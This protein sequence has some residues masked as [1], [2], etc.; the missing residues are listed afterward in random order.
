MT[1]LVLSEMYNA[2]AMIAPNARSKACPPQTVRAIELIARPTQAMA[3]GNHGFHYR[4]AL[5]QHLWKY[6]M[7]SKYDTCDKYDSHKEY[8]IYSKY[9]MYSK[10]NS[11]RVQHIQQVQPVQQVQLMQRVQHIEQV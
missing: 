8:S 9:G 11:R 6:N 7:Y 1:G 5:E 4:P 2:T 10:Y 3:Y